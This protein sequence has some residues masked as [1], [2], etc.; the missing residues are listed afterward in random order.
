[1]GSDYL[2][3]YS[4]PAT[5]SITIWMS[6]M[7]GPLFR[8]FVVLFL[9]A[10]N[11]NVAHGI[12]V[13]SSQSQE[14]AS[15]NGN[16]E[17]SPERKVAMIMTGLIRSLRFK[18]AV[19]L[20]KNNLFDALADNGKNQLHSFWRLSLDD[21]S[22]TQYVGIGAK[23]DGEQNED[24]RK[25]IEGMITPLQPKAIVWYEAGSDEA[26]EEEAAWFPSVKDQAART[27]APRLYSQIFNRWMNYHK[28]LEHETKTGIQ[29]DWFVDSRVDLMW[30]AKQP[31]LSFFDPKQ[32]TVS[33]LWN[34]NV[35]DIFLMVPREYADKVHSMNHLT[36]DCCYFSDPSLQY[37]GCFPT[38]DKQ[39]GSLKFS[40]ELTSTIN[41][42]CCASP[43]AENRCD[44]GEHAFHVLFSKENI[45]YTTHPFD[46]TIVHFHS[47]PDNTMS[48]SNECWRM[49]PMYSF[50][51]TNRLANK[52]AGVS[53]AS[54]AGCNVA[55][56]YFSSC[57][58]K[59]NSI[60]EA[61]ESLEAGSYFMPYAIAFGNYGKCLTLDGENTKLSSCAS[62]FF[63]PSHFDAGHDPTL[64][65]RKMLNDIKSQAY[66]PVKS[67]SGSGYHLQMMGDSEKCLSLREDYSQDSTKVSVFEARPCNM[68]KHQQWKLTSSNDGAFKMEIEELG[69][70][71]NEWNLKMMSNNKD[72]FEL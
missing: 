63:S 71:M 67:K 45:P 9:T 57:L 46:A 16:V 51:N 39:M 4:S 40:Q 35:P 32:V 65:E 28:A 24:L 66:F 61:P 36:N 19:D 49:G 64:E 26:T 27:A 52:G 58:E 72:S 14:K 62:H 48:I 59:G 33:G 42:Q 50:G 21:S 23:F 69:I 43:S 3:R 56:A 44:G 55:H 25:H 15:K 54:V 1:V 53:L 60:C 18:T 34:W 20:M 10:T 12:R 30:I 8:V 13:M 31:A 70:E 6:M 2:S 5:L 11:M 47:E 17:G 37:D 41:S 29:Y 22:P 7:A 38:A 68:S